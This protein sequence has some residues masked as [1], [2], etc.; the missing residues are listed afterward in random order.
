MEHPH[1]KNAVG[2]VT[3]GSLPSKRFIYPFFGLHMLAFGMSGFLMA[4]SPDTPSLAFLYMHGGIAIVVYVAFYLSIFGR[5][6][7]KWML[8]NAALGIVGIYAQIGWILERFGRRI[9]EYPWQVH[10]VPFLYYVLYTFLLRQFLI[11][12]TRSRDNPRRRAMVDRAYVLASVVVY[13]LLLWSGR[14]RG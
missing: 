5:D 3:A 13:G 9:E 10:V 14:G 7:V 2:G 11:D 12:V 4:Y 1:A 6:A 8:V